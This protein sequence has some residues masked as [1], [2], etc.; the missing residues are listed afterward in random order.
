MRTDP[1]VDE[2][3]AGAFVAQYRRMPSIAPIP[4]DRVP[5]RVTHSACPQPDCDLALARIRHVDLF[6][7]HWLI[8]AIANCS[9]HSIPPIERG[10]SRIFWRVPGHHPGAAV[11]RLRVV[12]GAPDRRSDGAVNCRTFRDWSR[13]VNAQESGHPRAILFDLDGTLDDRPRSIARYAEHFQAA[14]ADRLADA[15]LSNLAALLQT[16]DGDGYRRRDAVCDEVLHL[17][18]WHTT[19]A[20]QELVDHWFSW[21]PVSPAPREGLENVLQTLRARGISLG[22]VTNG[23]VLI[24]QTKIEHLGIGQYLSTVVISEAVHVSKPDPAIFALALAELDCAPA[25]VWFVGDHPVNDVLGAGAAG[26]RGIWLPA[27][28][29]WPS[30]QPEPASQITVL[31]DLLTLLDSPAVR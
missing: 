9:L 12:D 5:I 22:I 18:S 28:H 11:A 27:L 13:L 29:P 26:I 2:S 19:P 23:G 10:R 15:T 31:G 14:F 16:A 6:H 25:E 30:E 3:D 20:I 17:L 21:F 8:G 4:L 24:Q 1:L 7:C